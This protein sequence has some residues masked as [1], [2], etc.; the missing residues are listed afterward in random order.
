MLLQRGHSSADSYVHGQRLHQLL[1]PARSYLAAERPN[2][3]FT[4]NGI[5]GLLTAA[6]R[7]RVVT[8]PPYTS[9]DPLDL[10]DDVLGAVCE[11]HPTCTYFLCSKY[12]MGVPQFLYCLCFC[13]CVS[14]VRL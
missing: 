12:E 13:F 9:N 1:A 11:V 6:E 8:V 14:V 7:L 2:D 10:D 5:R 3:L 4:Q